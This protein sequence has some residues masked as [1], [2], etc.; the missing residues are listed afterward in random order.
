MNEGQK[1]SN[2]VLLLPG[3]WLFMHGV[4]EGGSCVC[5]VLLAKARWYQVGGLWQQLIDRIRWYLVDVG[6][7]RRF[8]GSCSERNRS[9]QTSWSSFNPSFYM[10][11]TVAGFL[12]SFLRSTCWLVGVDS[13][14]NAR[15][16]KPIGTAWNRIPHVNPRF[17][18]FPAREN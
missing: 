12:H 10:Y 7:A 8:Q 18:G 14:I 6:I 5:C 17:W 4:V 16:N 13:A 15:K 3:R 2:F 11:G 1:S 9:A